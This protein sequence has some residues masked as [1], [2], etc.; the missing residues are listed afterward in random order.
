MLIVHRRHVEACPHRHKGRDFRKCDCPL[1]IDWRVDGKRVQK[2]LGTR[3][4]GVAQLQARKIEVDGLES[5]IV[6]STVEAACDNFL[7]DAKSRQLRDESL[8]K[9]RQIFNQL[10]YYAKSKGIVFLNSLTTSE[11]L[12]FPATWNNSNLSAKKKLELLKAFFRFCADAKLIA[13][14]LAKLNREQLTPDKSPWSLRYRRSS[15][16]HGP[17]SSF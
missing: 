9:Y 15:V 1:W 12:E 6:P 14:S 8:R 11:L 5:A 7:A 16:A 2:P 4:W 3:D 17:P 13:N 10:K